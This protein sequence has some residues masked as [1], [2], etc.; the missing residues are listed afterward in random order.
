MKQISK[1]TLFIFMSMLLAQSCNVQAAAA[2][3]SAAVEGLKAAVPLMKEALKANTTAA[4]GFFRTCSQKVGAAAMTHIVRPAFVLTRGLVVTTA[5]ALGLYG[6]GKLLLEKG[7][8]PL[9]TPA[10]APIPV[11]TPKVEAP[12]GPWG[13]LF[14]N[15]WG[16]PDAP[17]VIAADV[18][19][20]AGKKASS[21]IP[22][23]PSIKEILS[24]VPGASTI[25]E[26]P[27]ASKNAAAWLVA[28]FIYEG[29]CKQRQLEK[30]NT[31]MNKGIQDGNAG[32]TTYG[33]TWTE[34]Q[35]ILAAS[36]GY[37]QQTTVNAR[38]YIDRINHG[39]LTIKQN[40]WIAAAFY[41]HPYA[42]YKKMSR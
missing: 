32:T 28:G 39:E 42:I 15:G 16:I 36:G 34:C 9:S 35:A 31:M 41:L 24:K 22:S 20:E 30:L 6:G 11:L 29:Y 25:A 12:Q 17:K 21:W 1:R 10:P 38:Q 37:P 26:Y 7:I 5:G 13:R 4:P 8:V 27:T 33:T 19:K 18:T 3:T 2:A 40:P 23:I 14:N